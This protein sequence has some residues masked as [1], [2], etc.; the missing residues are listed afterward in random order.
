M[1]S[2]EII[3]SSASGTPTTRGRRCV[4]PA[5]GSRPSLISGKPIW[6]V[7]SRTA[8][9]AGQRDFEPAS[10][11]RAMKRGHDGL[12]AA[13]QP[14]QHVVEQGRLRRLIHFPDVGARDEVTA[15]SVQD[16]RLHGGIVIRLH[17][18]LQ[19][20]LPAPD[21]KSHSPADCRS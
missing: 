12:L 19:Q 6:T 3:M 20:L 10:Q 16:D 18:R 14:Q 1:G 15:R 11:Y 5:P 9:V 7:F 8:K 4:P 2:P 17:N 21:A 13:F